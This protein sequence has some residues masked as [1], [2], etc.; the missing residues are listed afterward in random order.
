[1]QSVDTTDR[2]VHALTRR[3]SACR[4]LALARVNTEQDACSNRLP[5]HLAC[6]KG[7]TKHALTILLQVYARGAAAKDDQ[8]KLP[9]HH[10][11]QSGS[12]SPAVVLALLDAHPES[13]HARTAFGL[14]PHDE[15]CQPKNGVNMDPIIE[16]LDR[17]RAE[18]DRLGI[19][20]YFSVLGFK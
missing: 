4:K 5:L 10:A 14:T 17:F 20:L 9:V 12:C 6:K 8:E 15:A 16:V 19:S 18:H 2:A 11:C 13:I 7:I 3:I 1:M